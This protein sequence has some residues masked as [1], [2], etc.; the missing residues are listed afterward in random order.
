MEKRKLGKQGLEV[1]AL[2]LGCMGMTF[3]YH[4]ADEAQCLK[5][6]D[7]ALQLGVTFWDT[8]QSYGPF[9]NE[10]LLGK[11][12]RGRRSKVVVATKFAWKDG[13][14]GPDNLDGSPEN[15][16]QTLEGCLQRLGT[17]YVDLYYLH[18]LDPKVPI[19]ETVGAMGQLVKEGK[20]RYIGLSEV[21]P[22]TL[23]RAHAVHPLSALQSEYSL[24]ENGLEE[25][26]L[27]TLRELGIGLVPFSPVGRGFLTG[28]LKGFGD[29]GE[30]DMRRNLPRFQPEN[31]GENLRLVEEV[32][33][34]AAAKGATA[35]QIALAWLLHQGKDVVPIPGTTRVEH[36]EENAKAADIRLT[37]KDLAQI[38]EILS[39]IRVVGSRYNESMM[40]MVSAE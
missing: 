17:D 22:L 28:R 20:A 19:E 8:A 27:P 37:A 5:V 39:K 40:K 12:L 33:K 6:L 34:L 21:G 16:R 2:G 7:R 11:A 35:S 1:P 25:K 36:L 31:F 26:V 4:K 10:E 13:Q 38:E 23:R 29:L 15:A 9:T 3:A 18:R 14:A 24:W 32:Q 30:K